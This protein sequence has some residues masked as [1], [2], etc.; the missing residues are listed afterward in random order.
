MS[1]PILVALD[2]DH[3]DDCPLVLGARL[4]SALG[5]PLVVVG[6]YPHD[7][8][9]DAV[10]LGD[11]EADL[12][13]RTLRRLEAR[14]AG[15]PAE[16]RAAGG[17]TIGRVLHDV[18][19]ELGA[20]L[21]VA[22]AGRR[23]RHGHLWPG[24]TVEGLLRG[25]PCP[26]AITPP[27]LAPDW[28]PRRMGVGFVDGEDGHAALRAAAAIAAAGAAELR[29]VTAVERPDRHRSAAIPPY[30]GAGRSAVGAAQRELDDAVA[31]LSPPLPVRTETVV[32]DPGEALTALSA[33]L[34][35][36]VCGSRGYGPLR[37][38]L[39]GSVSHAVVREASCPVIVV[40]RRAESR[41]S[42]AAGRH[43]G[44]TA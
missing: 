32:A 20:G 25:S 6:A 1:K 21:I 43:E 41:L 40:P 44:A 24:S 37:G 31:A 26:V 36:L 14:T 35:L 34:D 12:R 27:G 11:H 29:V 15:Q 7:A 30:G 4:A 5:A 9:I 13:R 23:A 38:V 8:I 28:A 22:G 17:R 2:P 18:T 33:E 3:D 39:L 42:A 16:V 19:V 10:G